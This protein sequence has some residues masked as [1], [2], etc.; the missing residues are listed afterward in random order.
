MFFLIVGLGNPGKAYRT[1]RHN[2]GFR[3][4]DHLAERCS[5]EWGRKRFR[6]E[7]ATGE[8]TG[9]RVML[10]KPQTYM[11]LS[12]ESV[13]AASRYLK[14]GPGRIVV[15]HDDIDLALGRIQVR[16]GGGHGGHRGVESVLEDLQGADFYRVRIGVGRPEGAEEVSDFVLEEFSESEQELVQ[17]TVERASRAVEM[18]INDGLTAAMNKYNP[19]SANVNEGKGSECKK[20][21]T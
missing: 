14:I 10:L 11:N 9:K 4:V 15:V 5:I 20:T 19:W 3:A 7:C 1:S 2:I 8:V 16:L 21:D 17:D 12:G 18:L 13:G 6:A